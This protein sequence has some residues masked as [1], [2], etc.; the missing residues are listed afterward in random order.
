MVLETP[1]ILGG[2]IASYFTDEDLDLIRE[3]VAARSTFDS[4]VTY[5]LSGKCKKDAVAI[6]AA[7]PYIC[8]LYTSSFY[9]LFPTVALKCTATY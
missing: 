5:I 7:V 4:N 9:Y 2:H 1:V 8:L 6:G 3:K